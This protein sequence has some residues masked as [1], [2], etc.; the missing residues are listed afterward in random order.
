M[1]VALGHDDETLHAPGPE[2]NWNESRYIDFWDADTRI[3]GW[4]RIGV[5][6]NARYAEMSACL[7]LPD[8]RSAFTFGR[9]EVEGNVLT[10]SDHRGT[11]RWEI[12]KPWY[13]TRVR[14]EGDLTVFE[15]GWVLTDPPTAFKT[16]PREPAE[17]DVV[18]TT[19]GL[20]ATMGQD[21]D[22]HHLIFL[23][24]QADFHYQHMNHVVG[25]A[26]LGGESWKI[27][28]RGGKDHSWG[29]RNWHAKTY[30]RWLTC[31]VDDDN[32]FMLVRAVGPTTER[33][34]G[35]VWADR[36]FHVVD[37][38][39]LTSHYAG[40]PHYELERAEV[41]VRAGDTTWT[42]TA[43]PQNAVPARHRQPGPDGEEAILR[44]VK[45]PAE[46]VL[47]DGRQAT[48]HIEYHDI[49]RDGVPVGLHE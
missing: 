48:G 36:A 7:Y 10:V 17:I 32:G 41:K 42:A 18:C 45:Y 27:D 19:Q 1:G 12:T 3:G 44:I 16:N 24:G 40:A 11:Q 6:P 47:G 49:V 39:E 13:E 21:Q 5:R 26:R 38:F 29:P 15:D 8:G 14:F 25:T 2:E 4:F 33:R 28:G 34:G 46:W 31:C 20:E 23:P 9:P 43:T 35:H 30:L 37:D 22:Q